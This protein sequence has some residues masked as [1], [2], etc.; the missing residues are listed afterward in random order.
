MPDAIGSINLPQRQ[1]YGSS[2]KTK[3]LQPR[4]GEPGLALVFAAAVLVDVAVF[5]GFEEDDLADAFFDVDAEGEVGEV[6]EFDDE[7]A[8]PAGFEGGGVDEEAGAGVGGLAHGDAGDAAG[9]AEGLDRD[10]EGV[11]VRGH[12]VVLRAVLGGAQ[13]GLGERGLV[14]VLGVY[15]AA[16]DGGEDAEAV[17]GEAHVVA[18]RGGPGGDYAAALDLADELGVE[19]LDE[20]V[21]FDHA[22][23]PAVRLNCHFKFS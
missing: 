11:G 9:H 17:V 12:E 19:G 14:E 22:P 15:L 6:G 3:S 16:V 4:I 13:G 18:V 5:V 1:T 8:G 21:L 20:L 10:A 7:A 23:Y 2:F